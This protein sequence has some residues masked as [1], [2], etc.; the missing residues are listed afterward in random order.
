MTYAASPAP[1]VVTLSNS[2][3]CGDC[4][5]ERRVGRYLTRGAPLT[6]AHADAVLRQCVL[7]RAWREQHLK[8]G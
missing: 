5:D 4:A 1:C 2:C 6:P 7:N 3:L 8:A